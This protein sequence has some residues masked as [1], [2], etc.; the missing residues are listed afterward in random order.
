MCNKKIYDITQMVRKFI[1]SVLLKFPVD[2]NSQFQSIIF[3]ATTVV[4]ISTSILK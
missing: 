4:Y 2:K 3:N 1:A